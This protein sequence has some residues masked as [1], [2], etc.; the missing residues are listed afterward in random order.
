MVGAS[1]QHHAHSQQHRRRRFKFEVKGFGIVNEICVLSLLYQLD[2]VPYIWYLVY[3]NNYI[4]AILYW[5][6]EILADSR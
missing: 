5:W 2:M 4:T 3:P 1:Q 6:Y